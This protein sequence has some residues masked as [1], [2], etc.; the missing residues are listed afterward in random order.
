MITKKTCFLKETIIVF[1]SDIELIR[2]VELKEKI[3]ANDSI[4]LWNQHLQVQLQLQNDNFCF[5]YSF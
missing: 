2:S 5:T 4:L 3:I 1:L